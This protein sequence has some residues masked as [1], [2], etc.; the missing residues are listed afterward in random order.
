MSE[1]SDRQEHRDEI[2]EHRANI[3]RLFEKVNAIA[4]DIGI[5]RTTL[6]LRRE[7]PQPGLCLE[8]KAG[9]EEVRTDVNDLKTSRAEVRFGLS[10]W[11]WLGGAIASMAGLI[12]AAKMAFG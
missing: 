1:D 2:G 4:V 9:L 8:L 12:F 5:I 3:A 10:S 11:I 6:D 7:C